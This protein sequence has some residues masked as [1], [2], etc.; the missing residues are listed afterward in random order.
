MAETI[1][2]SDGTVYDKASLVEDADGL[3]AQMGGALALV[4]PSASFEAK[5]KPDPVKVKAEEAARAREAAV[6]AE[7]RAMA[8]ERLAAKGL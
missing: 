8:E 2:A 5:R 7:M 3:W 4:I 1:T 6:Q